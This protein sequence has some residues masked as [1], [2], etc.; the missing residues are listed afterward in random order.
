MHICAER[1]FRLQGDEGQ[2]WWIYDTKLAQATVKYPVYSVHQDAMGPMAFA[3]VALAEEC[4]DRYDVLVRDSLLWFENRPECA[5]ESLIDPDRGVVWRAV[6]L[7]D[8]STTGR[9]GLSRRELRR[10]GRAVWLGRA[11]KR[12]NSAGFVHRECR[13][14]HPGWILAADALFER[15]VAGRI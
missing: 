8:P 5:D 1:L 12:S 13:P 7:D 9:L 10:M 2:W 3:M 15:C 4:T 11:D 6:Q 14:Y